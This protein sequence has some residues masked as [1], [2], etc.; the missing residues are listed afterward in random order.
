MKKNLLFMYLCSFLLTSSCLYAGDNREDP[1]ESEKNPISV[2]KQEISSN[3]A[4]TEEDV[5]LKN[6]TS[7][8][9]E[10][11]STDL[12]LGLPDEMWGEVF[13]FLIIGELKKVMHCL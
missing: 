1:E 4:T 9:K 6:L 8:K 5:S 12:I 3:T 7:I 10:E 11:S 2:A 13:S